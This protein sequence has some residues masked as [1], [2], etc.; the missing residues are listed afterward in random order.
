[1]GHDEDVERVTPKRAT[2]L[3]V[4]EGSTDRARIEEALRR[5]YA[6]DYE[7]SC[8]SSLT[9][10]ERELRARHAADEQVAAVLVEQS[11]PDTD[12]RPF[13]QTV[14][15]LHP[16][17]KRVL[18][19]EWGAWRDPSTA[20]AVRAAMLEAKIDYYAAKPSSSHDEDFHRL[21]TEF[22][23]EWSRAHSATA[24]EATLIGQEG[25][26][27]VHELRS[28]L[29]GSGVPYR[30]EEHGSAEARRLL[31]RENGD[32]P[33]APAPVLVVRDGRVLNDPSNAELGEAFGVETELGPERDFDVVVIGAGP[34]GLTAA[35]YA[36]SEGLSTLV[37]DRAGIGGQAGTSSLIRNYLGFSRGISGGELAQRAYQQAWVFGARFA[38]MRE[39]RALRRADDGWVVA[40]NGQDEAT[41]RGVVLATGISY[42][43]LGIPAL[44]RLV[45]SG[46]F[47]GAS[48]SEART[49]T[50]GH[51]F[52]VGGGNSAGQAAMHLSRHAASVTVVVRGRTLASSMSHYLQQA[53]AATPNV[54]VRTEA[55]VVDGGGGD[56]LEHV[57]L[58]LRSSGE[59]EVL[60]ASGLFIMIG[61]EPLTDWLPEEI[62]RDDSGY[63]LTGLDLV[64]GGRVVGRWPLA[65]APL[66]LE[67]SA[68]GVF[69]IGDVRHGSTKRV[70]SGAGEGSVVVAELHRLLDLAS[71]GDGLREAR[72]P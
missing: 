25:S 6:D 64:Q 48:V 30:F 36:S 41:A 37:I 35:V 52:V 12:L 70:A 9:Q 32:D 60:P 38:L 63:L 49:L 3:A 4:V 8:A 42:R 29:A 45:G 17:A 26:P 28:L 44:E 14:G 68:P 11:R 27:R 7:L 24:S 62:A 69:A 61:A 1:M 50:D 15:D 66:T 57:T 34:A 47:Y 51:A 53:L 71:A 46:V 23:Q 40:L 54:S 33:A 43:R 55:E 56:K 21:L 58:R 2:I 16:F 5:R 19:I 13:L 31:G 22:L 72:R 10:A 20:A 18:L 39:A 67:T 65:R 59:T